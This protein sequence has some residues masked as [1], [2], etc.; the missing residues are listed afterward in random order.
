MILTLNNYCEFTD[1]INLKIQG[2][3]ILRNILIFLRAL[4]VTLLVQGCTTYSGVAEFGVYRTTFISAHSAGNEIL[5]RVAVAEREIFNIAYPLD[6]ERTVF[7]PA[8]ASYFVDTV[9]PPTV[10]A[11]RRTLLAVQSYNDALYGLSS[12]ED[13]SAL[14]GKLTRL[15][16]IGVSAATDAVALTGAGA[17]SGLATLLE[18]ANAVNIVLK[19]LEPLAAQTISFATREEFRKKLI[20][21]KYNIESALILIRKGTPKI[22][23]ILQKQVVL[24]S[25]NDQLNYRISE[26]DVKK[27]KDLRVLVSLL[28]ILID[29]TI[30]S[31]NTAVESISKEST[32]SAFEGILLSSE[33]LS[34]TVRQVRL[35]LVK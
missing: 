30:S 2:M 1:F 32:V 24:R 11:Y 5:D 26:S 7:D 21:E 23:E 3:G 12:G 31:L 19:G 4:F 18:N 20:Q 29:T 13:A 27:I 28:V 15:G 10:A 25:Q 8:L 6:P 34:A 9:D 22:F 35:N 17:T 33:N 14:A 16:A